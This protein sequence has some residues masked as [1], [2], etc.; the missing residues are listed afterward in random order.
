VPRADTLLERCAFA[1]AALAVAVLPERIKEHPRLQPYSTTWAHLV[2]AYAEVVVSVVL[3]IWGMVGA[4]SS[5]SYGPAW[6]YLVRQPQLTHRD[7]FAMGA[8]GFLVY[9]AQPATWVLLYGFAEGLVR[10]LEAAFW[11]RRLGLGVVWLGWQLGRQALRGEHRLRLGVMLGPPR[12][13][14]IVVQPAGQPVA[15]EVFSV[16]DKSWSENQVVEF[17]GAFYEL[18][19]RELV[20]RGRWYAWRYELA[21]LGDNEV[22]RGAVVRLVVPK[23]AENEGARA[24]GGAGPQTAPEPAARRRATPARDR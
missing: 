4:V 14:E 11:D 7:F 8:L 19:G 16:E 2:S 1:V 15:L 18:I 12:P 24:A 20:A 10:A 22:I 6:E 17:G 21:L 23:A 13:D 3:F 9:L 5:F